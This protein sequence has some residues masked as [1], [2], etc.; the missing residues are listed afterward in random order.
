MTAN[1]PD[2]QTPMPGS[3]FFIHN[4]GS[5]R[6]YWWLDTLWIVLADS[7]D[8]GGRYSLMEEV[9]SKGSG[10][11]PHK[12][13]WSDETYYIMDGEITFLVG[14]EIKTARTGDY[15]MVCLLYTSRCV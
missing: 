6:A 3:E 11:G 10:P 2:A 12:H 15:V 13:T 8:T 7:S 5:A 9:A 4:N 1:T 14:D